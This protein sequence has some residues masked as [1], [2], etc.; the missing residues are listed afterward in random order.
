M[1][2]EAAQ[3]IYGAIQELT[4]VPGEWVGIGAIR[5]TV[6]SWVSRDEFSATLVNMYALGILVIA[7]EDNQKILTAAD[8]Y[9]G[10]T[11]AGERRHL[12]TLA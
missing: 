8:Q 12:V 1:N 11:V 2:I 9:N 3:R 10:V 5:D 4:T 7:P 6:G